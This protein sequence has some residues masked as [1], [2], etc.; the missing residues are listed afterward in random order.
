M[1]TGIQIYENRFV[2]EASCPAKGTNPNIDFIVLYDVSEST[3]EKNDFV[4][5]DASRPMWSFIFFKSQCKDMIV[6]NNYIYSADKSG[7]MI[8]AMDCSG[9]FQLDQYPDRSSQGGSA[10]C[11]NEYYNNIVVGGSNSSQ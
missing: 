6:R 2:Y 7:E 11:N 10:K 9:E 8:E 5:T 1:H 4:D 3:I